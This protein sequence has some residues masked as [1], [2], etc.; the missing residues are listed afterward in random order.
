M[1][2]AFGLCIEQYLAEN[3]ITNY[4]EELFKKTK[5]FYKKKVFGLLSIDL[6][7]IQSF[8]YNIS[9]EKHLKT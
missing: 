3:E 8:I 2:A 6:S 4:K 7:G 1:T 5:D 9:D